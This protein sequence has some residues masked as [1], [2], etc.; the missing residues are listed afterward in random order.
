MADFVHQLVAT[1]AAVRKLGARSISV[2]EAEQT[3][4]NPRVVVRDFRGRGPRWRDDAR[5]LLIGTTDGGR[6]LTL[7]IEATIDPTTWWLVTG[8]EATRAERK[9]GGT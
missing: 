1:R 7:V 3:L 5:R 6:A 8:W 4:H 9:I 2:A